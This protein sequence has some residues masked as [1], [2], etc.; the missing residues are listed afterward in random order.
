MTMKRKTKRRAR[1]SNS[2]SSSTK[3]AEAKARL[4]FLASQLKRS[5]AARKAA[6]ARAEAAEL[7]LQQE[8]SDRASETLGFIV[9]KQRHEQLLTWI[10]LKKPELLKLERVVARQNANAAAGLQAPLQLFLTPRKRAPKVLDATT[11]MGNP[12]Q[13]Y[14]QQAEAPSTTLNGAAHDTP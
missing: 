9:A 8:Q 12:V 4:T 14:E 13:G 2:R 5:I 3:S 7:R 10:N 11:Q 6:E 1:P